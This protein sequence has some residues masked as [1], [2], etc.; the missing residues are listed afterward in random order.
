M[1]I[2]R[3]LF[4]LFLIFILCFIV[5]GGYAV[6]LTDGLESR[7]EK[8]LPTLTNAKNSL[9]ERTPDTQGDISL[10][11]RLSRLAF[12]KQSV[13]KALP[14]KQY[15]TI[16]HI[17]LPLQQSII[18]I[19]DN[20]FYSHWGFDITGI[21]RASLVNL[22]YGRI[23]EGASTITQQL[24]KNLFLS[25]EQSMGRKAEELLLALDVEAR[26]SKEQILE[27][28]LNTIYFG[29]DYYGIAEAAQG[30]FGKKPQDLTLAESA[31]LA[32][33]PNAPSLYSP[34]VNYELAKKRQAVVLD[35]MVRGGLIAPSTA[36][37]AKTERL[38]FLHETK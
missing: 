1:R 9:T 24:V 17:A 21:L 6:S 12:L 31:M 36:E 10:G 22:Q 7:L 2:L 30:Y 23:E 15:I 35:A 34:Y 13:N 18:A 28:Y 25:R 33:L 14:T 19:E 32:G 4:F 20:R 8:Q 26:Y 16:D 3:F 5:S 11:S 29:S 38:D 27:L 37:K